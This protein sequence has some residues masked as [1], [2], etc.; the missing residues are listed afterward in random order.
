MAFIS[1]KNETVGSLRL[2]FIVSGL[3]LLV[4]LSMAGFTSPFM[5]QNL[6]SDWI[7]LVV[8]ITGISYL[9]FG[10]ALKQYLSPAKVNILKIWLV[11]SFLLVAAAN[12]ATMD[13]I[14]MVITALIVFYLFSAVSRLS[15]A[16]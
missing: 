8:T 7:A 12:V 14:S 16:L 15:K 2:Y 6:Y 13:Y 1:P 5:Y 3:L 10:L 4:N 9:Y 11:L